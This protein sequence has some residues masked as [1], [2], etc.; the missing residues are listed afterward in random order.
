MVEKIFATFSRR[1]SD[2]FLKTYND[3]K[4]RE[5]W[6][7]D[8]IGL[9]I[10]DELAEQGIR[11][12]AKSN[13]PPSPAEFADM[14]YPSA[15]ELKIPPCVVAFQQVANN[16]T[17]MHPVVYNA[18]QA[19]GVQEIRGNPPE[20][21]YSLF[22]AYYDRYVERARYGEVFKI[23]EKPKQIEHVEDK[24]PASPETVKQHLDMMKK[25]IGA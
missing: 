22:K 8:L 18:G 9:D 23:P 6:F 20:K 21:T 7:R 15:D 25:F 2:R 17:E 19:V 10:T 11:R 1:Y 4:A 12:S 24:T 16:F 13:W 5:V 3:E 14:C